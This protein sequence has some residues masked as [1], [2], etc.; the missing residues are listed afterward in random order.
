MGVVGCCA[1]IALLRHIQGISIPDKC[2][3]WPP[4][5]VPIGLLWR[6]CPVTDRSS[7][8]LQM[9]ASSATRWARAL[10]LPGYHSAV[11]SGHITPNA[12]ILISR[13]CQTL[14][15]GC[16]R[17]RS[18]LCHEVSLRA[19]VHRCCC[20]CLCCLRSFPSFLDCREYEKR[21]STGPVPAHGAQLPCAASADSLTSSPC[22]LPDMAAVPLASHTPCLVLLPLAV[23]NLQLFPCPLTSALP[24][25]SR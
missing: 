24:A 15:A 7:V 18:L 25:A 17:R 16:G 12:S 19:P 22:R 23:Q 3:Q 1:A 10:Q 4:E 11:K 9:R 8:L 6:I 21:V 13:A 5:A 20:C 14:P 2:N